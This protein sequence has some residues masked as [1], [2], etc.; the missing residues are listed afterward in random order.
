MFA[1]L[2]S[3]RF[4]WDKVHLFWVDERGVAPG[5]ADFFEFQKRTHS[6]VGTLPG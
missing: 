2:A 4:D 5:G 6:S 3:A 1:E